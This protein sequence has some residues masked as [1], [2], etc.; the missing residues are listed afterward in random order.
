MKY[1]ACFDIGGTYIKFGV[2]SSSGGIFTTGKVATPKE[3]AAIQIPEIIAQQVALMRQKYEIQNIGISACGL[4]DHER[5]EVLFSANIKDY[6]GLQLARIVKEKTNL[7]VSVENDV[8]CACLGEVWLGAAQG[9]QDVVLLTLG[10]GIGGA[11]VINGQLMRGAGYL[12]GELGHMSIVHDGESCPCGFSGCLERYA[13]TGALVRHY[14]RISGN[15]SANGKEIMDLVKKQDPHAK[16]AYDRFLNYLSTGLVNITHLYNPDVIIIG[17]G[18][19]AQGKSLLED[20]Q[21]KYQHKVMDVY[22][23]FTEITLAKLRNHAALYGAYTVVN[24]VEE[25]VR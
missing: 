15:D 16:E 10:T 24:Q 25:M 14:T 21:E 5:G 6:S 1:S 11:V 12:A 19:T 13:S 17:G 2:I 9:K 8:R 22:K 20:I 4:I 23:V 3:N 18:I 7:H